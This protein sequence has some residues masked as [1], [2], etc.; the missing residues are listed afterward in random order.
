M[1]KTKTIEEITEEEKRMRK[2][3]LYSFGIGIV[4]VLLEVGYGKITE[5]FKEDTYEVFIYP[6][7]YDLT[8]HRF[9]GTYESIDE[10]REIVLQE[11]VKYNQPD[12]EIGKN[13]ENREGTSLR[14][15]EETLK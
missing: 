2:G 13:C 11:I 6:N 4:L 14:V 1:K 9:I 3:F 15:C 5:W 12:Y 8:N 10:A 7:R